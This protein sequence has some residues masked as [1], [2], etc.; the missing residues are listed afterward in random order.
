MNFAFVCKKFSPKTLPRENRE[1][2]TDE[3]QC[4]PNLLQFINELSNTTKVLG[5]LGFGDPAEN[6]SFS[7]FPLNS[8][9]KKF[10]ISNRASKRIDFETILLSLAPIWS[11]CYRCQ[12]TSWNFPENFGLFQFIFPNNFP[13]RSFWTP[14][15]WD[16]VSCNF[17]SNI[18]KKLEL[19]IQY[20]RSY[21]VS[22]LRTAQGMSQL[23]HE[24]IAI[25]SEL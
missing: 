12:S 6:M 1:Q 22:K 14:K 8:N 11:K 15:F 19:S 25:K 13:T 16:M 24:R 9:R 23:R 18:F 2:S 4:L 21:N 20:D 10:E 3:S 17:A 7:I 5:S